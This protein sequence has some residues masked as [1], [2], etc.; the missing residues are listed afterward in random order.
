[1]DSAVKTQ[2]VAV[3]AEEQVNMEQT[4]EGILWV[5]SQQ[6][7]A[8]KI[9]EENLDYVNAHSTPARPRRS[10][11]AKYGKRVLDIALSAAALIVLSPVNLVLLICTW[12]DV[13]RPVLFRQ[14]RIGK[15]GKVFTLIKFRNMT[16]ECDANG[17]LL[18]ADQRVTR[19]GRFVRRTSLDELLNFWSIFK[20]DMSIIGPRPMPTV[21]LERF[22]ERHKARFSVRPGLECPRLHV[23]DNASS[24]SERFENDVYYAE[25]VS[26]ALDVKMLFLLA[27]MVF[28]PKTKAVRE[29]GMAGSFM[30]YEKN[31]ACIN[32]MAVPARYVQYIYSDV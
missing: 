2:T 11:Y 29:D 26:L 6:R 16:N 8:Q 9:K 14:E 21:Y 30:G 25:H 3:S 5:E 19:L 4:M 18:P 22:S 12:L 17:D 1:M 23:S 28:D 31:G 24:W 27:K 7:T 13:G 32:S 15:D 10:F 20:G